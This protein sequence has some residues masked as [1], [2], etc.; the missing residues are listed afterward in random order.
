M[1]APIAGTG[2]LRLTAEAPCAV[3]LDGDALATLQPGDTTT[4]AL[5]PD[6][7]SL[8]ATH[9][10]GRTWTQTVTIGTGQTTD[11]PIAFEDA[12]PETPEEETP[13]RVIIRPK[14]REPSS[15]RWAWA[16]L[17]VLTV[18]VGAATY[19]WRPD[20]AQPVTDA[21]RAWTGAFGATETVTTTEDTPVEIPLVDGAEVPFTVSLL[22]PPAEGT[23][24]LTPDSTRA[25]YTPAPDFAGT[26]R[27]RYRLQRGAQQDTIDVTVRVSPT[28]DRPIARDDT[29]ATDHATAIPLDVLVNDR[30]P[31]A[32]PLR[33]ARADAP[34]GGRLTVNADSTR[35]TFAP[36]DTFAGTARF[37]YAIA[38]AQNATDSATV[39][40]VVEPPPPT[41]ADVDIAWQRIEAGSF[42]MGSQGGAVDAQPSHRVR[43]TRPFRMSAHEVTV[44]Q[45]RQFVAATGHRT[46]AERAGG[47]WPAGQDSLLRPGLTWRTPGFPQTDDHPVV[48]VS[49]NDAQAFAE[50]MGARLPTE[51]EWEYAARAGVAKNRLPGEWGETTWYAEN[52]SGTQPV[53]QKAPNDWGLYDVQ[54]NVW[55]WVQDW[56]APDYYGESPAADPQGPDTGTLRVCRG[57]SWANE[58]C[59]L[60]L[61]NRASPTYRSTNIG[62]RIVRPATDTPPS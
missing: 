9:D 30:H 38:D 48:N 18:G 1:P 13:E 51:A 32:Q 40:V 14:R 54:G 41:P 12:T 29:F 43:I 37:R 20:L 33:I 55:E 23:L 15:A 19:A 22:A 44:G 50:W 28:P 16:L 10:D 7:Y 62:F 47:A 6:T 53:G 59:W 34:P 3:T 35:L 8:T 36:A 26:D 25:T 4:L 58:A 49:W 45:F 57:G 46:D 2:T 11:V 31:D 61:R 39:R 17:V 21:V 56:Y 27:F 5:L 24:A 60:P 52:A 42:V